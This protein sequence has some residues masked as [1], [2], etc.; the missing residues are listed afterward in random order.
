MTGFKIDH[1]HGLA[2]ISGAD[3]PRFGNW[4]VVYTLND[5]KQVYVGESLNVRGRFTQ[6]LQSPEKQHL[7]SVRVVIDDS[8]NK[9][10]AL[11]LESQLV[12]LLAGDGKYQVLN[13][14]DGI[15]DADYF[16]RATYQKRFEQIFKQL[17]AD[18]LFENP[19]RDIENSHLFKLSPFKALNP[20]QEL[21]VQRF[22]ANLIVSEQQDAATQS[23]VQGDPG[24]GKTIVGIY[25]M[26][27][28][29]DLSSSVI[30]DDADEDSF[31]SDPFVVENRSALSGFKIGFVVPQQSLRRSVES[32]F[33]KT[34][35]LSKAMV[36]TPFQV[37]EADD[38]FDLLIVDETH[39]LNR[40]ANQSS[41]SAN[42]RFKAINEKLF[43]EDDPRWTQLDWIEAQSKHQVLLLDAGQ[44]V[45]PADLDRGHLSSLVRNA[46][47]KESFYP[48]NSQMRIKNAVE[49]IQYLRG[50]FSNNPPQPKAF[51]EYD[52]RWFENLG[53]ME[54]ALDEQESRF[55]L[56]RMVAGYAWKWVS[57]KDP[58]AIDI[59]IDGV[60]RKWNVADKDWINS[61]TAT[62][63]VGS[64]H[65]TQG[66]D[67]NYAGV[68]IGND[69]R[70]DPDRKR[71]FF[72]RSNYFD[73]QGTQNLKQLGIEMTDND[74]LDYVIN[75][76]IVL[77]TRGIRGTFVYV[78]DPAL[79]AYLKPFFA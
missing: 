4:P 20:G 6:H 72:D 62:E 61:A 52:L 49:Y 2:F 8:F 45:R 57:K 69:L 70:Y 43:G 54:K 12:R 58:T 59:E 77:L 74:L 15:V 19:V 76:Y 18:G 51:P 37:G 23:V 47:S 41:A 35:G 66:Y 53:D 22:L 44:S 65:T 56:A 36:L 27:L 55:G 28:I 67:L 73:R 17:H 9:S 60:R 40:R 25:L 26:K 50:V 64:I 78:C 71:L 34:P 68:I 42:K 32:V 1:F 30:H 24:T 10:A 13:R 38:K 75:I 21:M 33:A 16:D 29:S 7:K 46:K 11:D 5:D 14:N 63:E 3:D 31:F 79:R 39:R 48:L